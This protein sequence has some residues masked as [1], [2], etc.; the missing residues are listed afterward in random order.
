MLTGR[1]AVQPYNLDASSTFAPDGFN[2]SLAGDGTRVPMPADARPGLRRRTLDGAHGPEEPLG[3]QP[4]PLARLDQEPAHRE[5]VAEND[6]GGRDPE[7]R[8]GDCTALPE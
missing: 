8:R 3:E 4:V 6:H 1:G 5:S 2:A 7:V